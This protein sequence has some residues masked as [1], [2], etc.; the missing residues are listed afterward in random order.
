MENTEKTQDWVVVPKATPWA[1]RALFSEHFETQEAAEQYALDIQRDV[2]KH[3]EIM[4]AEFHTLLHW[5]IALQSIKHKI[6][7]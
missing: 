2:Y 4:V 3:E 1:T 6:K 5:D 7:S